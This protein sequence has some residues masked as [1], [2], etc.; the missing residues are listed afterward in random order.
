[1]TYTC[2]EHVNEYLDADL[3]TVAKRLVKLLDTVEVSDNDREFHP[4]TI[5]SYRTLH[6]MELNDLLPRLRELVKKSEWEP[7]DTF[8]NRMFSVMSDGTPEGTEV[9]KYKGFGVPDYF[10]FWK[11]LGSLPKMGE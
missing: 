4:T 2:K 3:S 11:P 9:F 10:K 8:D 1:M 7:I 6:V 5:S